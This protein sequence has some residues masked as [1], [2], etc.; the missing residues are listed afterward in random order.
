MVGMSILDFPKILSLSDRLRSSLLLGTF[1]IEGKQ[2]L[3]SSIEGKQSLYSP[4]E[5][6][7]ASGI[8]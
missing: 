4:I 5:R 2:S 3:Y 1:S 7:E 6:Q 8:R